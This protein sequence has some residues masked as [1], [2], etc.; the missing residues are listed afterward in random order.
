M[1]DDLTNADTLDVRTLSRGDVAAMGDTVLGH[2][3]RRMLSTD[4]SGDGGRSAVV[5]AFDS[6]V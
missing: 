6:Y 1:D 5:A 3:V 4:G 2:A